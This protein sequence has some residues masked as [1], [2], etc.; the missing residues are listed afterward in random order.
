MS[1]SSRKVFTVGLIQETWKVSQMNCLSE[2][3]SDATNKQVTPGTG[4]TV[5]INQQV[6]RDYGRLT[7]QFVYV[8]L[9][10]AVDQR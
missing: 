6:I 8:C 1:E 4:F 7:L 10:D 9:L 3:T 5:T 2:Q